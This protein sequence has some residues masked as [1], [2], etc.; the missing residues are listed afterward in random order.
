MRRCL[1]LICIIIAAVLIQAALRGA[2]YAAADSLDVLRER[3]R[4]LTVEGRYE[5]LIHSTL[6]VYNKSMATHDR[7]AQECAGIHLAQAYMPSGKY[8]SVYYYLD[9]VEPGIT[10]GNDAGLKIIMNN[11]K[12]ILAV[13]I[14]MNYAEAFKFF[15][16]AL[17]ISREAGL[18]YQERLLLCNIAHLYGV[19]KDTAGYSYARDA[20]VLCK[21]SHDNYTLPSAT[22]LLS[23][24][25]SL[26]EQYDSAMKYADEVMD[27]ALSKHDS[28]YEQIAWQLAGSIYE[29]QGDYGQARRSYRKALDMNDR[30]DDY[31]ARIGIYLTYGDFLR[32]AGDLDEARTMFETGLR[33]ASERRNIE[34]VGGFLFG[35]SDVCAR[36]GDSVAAYEYYR[37]YDVM[38]RQEA[39][40]EREFNRLYVRFTSIQHQKEISERELEL[41][42]ANHR[43]LVGG[44]LLFVLIVILA[45]VFYL[46]KKKNRMYR[47]LV[48]NHYR[49]SAAI[50]HEKEANKE[51]RTERC[52]PASTGSLYDR[53]EHLMR[54]GKVY[55]EKDLSLDRLAAMLDSN[56]SYVSR[57][58]NT[59][60]GMSFY[61]YINHYRIEEAV[62][63]LQ[64]TENNTPLKALCEDLGFT[65][66]SVFYRSFQKETGVPPARYREEMRRIKGKGREE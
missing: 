23:E 13:Q 42:K 45:V 6:E 61:N 37:Q 32:E 38:Q 41:M 44:V 31:S 35:L 66:I 43:L 5:E 17:D 21:E 29:A 60:S 63:V 34:A 20:Y 19:R 9:E 4:S 3:W 18:D 52:E 62:C 64:D 54:T 7:Y 47:Q 55:R 51:V 10:A 25:Y 27:I 11:V 50:E 15:Q 36:T 40:S 59:C 33:L 39:E 8:D 48:E 24:M 30:I 46:Y 49:M 16:E 14:E 58:I 1:Y 22:V 12:A 28:S 57:E 2:P 56:R 65:S 26:R 53:I